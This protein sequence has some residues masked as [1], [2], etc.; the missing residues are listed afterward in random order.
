MNSKREIK[1]NP[2]ELKSWS[3]LKKH[4]N[5]ININYKKNDKFKSS[6]LKDPSRFREFSYSV[7]DDFFVDFS[8][9]FVTSETIDLFLRLSDEINLSDEISDMFSGKLINET[10]NR[11]VL[12]TAM[13]NSSEDPVFLNGKNIMPEVHHEL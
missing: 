10:E 2:E 7:F 11:A 5:D 13:R 3:E 9:N 6:V 8:K 1:K 4:F 12:H